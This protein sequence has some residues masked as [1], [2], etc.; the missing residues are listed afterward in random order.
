MTRDNAFDEAVQSE[1]ELRATGDALAALPSP[2]PISSA[3]KNSV[4]A[5]VAETPQDN[6]I[7]LAS[8]RRRTPRILQAAAA[9]VAV[10]GVGIGAAMLWPDAKDEPGTSIS[11]D[12]GTQEMHAIM[13]ASDV[14][15]TEMDAMGANLNIVVSDSMGKGGAMVDGAPRVENGMG[16]Q[17]WAVSTDGAMHSAGVIGPEEHNDVWMPLPAHIRKVVVTMEPIA[18]SNQPTGPIVAESPL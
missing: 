2:K 3:L 8:R 17:V 10:A 4:L 13:E 6:V 11:A 5:A 1:P 12:A 15:N 18:G 16:A 14:R 9:L 7:S